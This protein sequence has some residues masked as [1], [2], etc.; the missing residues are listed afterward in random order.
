M[1]FFPAA[2]RYALPYRAIE[3][4]RRSMLA[5]VAAMSRDRKSTELQ[6][7]H[8]CGVAASRHSDRTTGEGSPVSILTRPAVAQPDFDAQ[9][10]DPS[11]GRGAIAVHARAQV[12]IHARFCSCPRSVTACGW[13]Q[14]S[15]CT[16]PHPRRASATSRG[17]ASCAENRTALFGPAWRYR[18]RTGG[19]KTTGCAPGC[20]Q[21]VPLTYGALPDPPHHVLPTNA[22]ENILAAHA[23][24]GG[25]PTAC[26]IFELCDSRLAVAKPS[27]RA[28]QKTGQWTILDENGCPILTVEGMSLQ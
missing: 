3:M 18:H 16:A 20:G 12:H 13:L 17:A 9:G 5:N 26:F 1:P 19:S 8:R 28:A 15:A 23:S 7:N 14:T 6:A 22:L 25:P 11:R 10:G 2:G 21:P 27:S 4:R 24:V